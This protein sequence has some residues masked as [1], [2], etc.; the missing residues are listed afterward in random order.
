[1]ASP[2]AFPPCPGG[3]DAHRLQTVLSSSPIWYLR[4]KTAFPNPEEYDPYRWLTPDGA[5]L[6]D[7]LPLRD[8]YYIPFSKGSNV[9]IGA[10]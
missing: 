10:Q 3:Q 4:D 2:I 6:S 1:M 5:S 8:K 9:C 7:G